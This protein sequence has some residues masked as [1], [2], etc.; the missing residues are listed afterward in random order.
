MTVTVTVRAGGCC[1]NGVKVRTFRELADLITER[2]QS[3]EH[4]YQ[5]AGPAIGTGTVNA[6][7]RRLQ[8]SVRHLG[9]LIRSDVADPEARKLLDV[10]EDAAR[11][12]AE[13]VRSL[14]H[15]IREIRRV[16]VDRVL[17]T[18]ADPTTDPRS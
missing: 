14:S 9:R 10:I 4:R 17:A 11:R 16:T 18:D 12:V 1:G 2:V 15:V 3:E 6:F 13:D 5:W 7:V 8:A